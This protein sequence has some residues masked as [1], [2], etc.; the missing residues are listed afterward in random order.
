MRPRAP[1][2]HTRAPHRLPCKYRTNLA[3]LFVVHCDLPL[4]G[5]LA[6]LG[7]LLSADFWRKV[8]GK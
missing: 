8:C 7:P 3:R 2:M 5:A 6:T 1:P 4:W